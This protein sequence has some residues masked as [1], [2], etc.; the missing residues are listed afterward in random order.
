MFTSAASSDT[1]SIASQYKGYFENGRRYQSVSSNEYYQPAGIACPI[2]QAKVCLANYLPD[3]KQWE[4]MDEGHL[5][6]LIL[7]SQRSNPL[8]RSPVPKSAQ[9]I[10]DVGTGSGTWALEVADRW[11][12]GGFCTSV[13]KLYGQMY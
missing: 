1:T 2:D 4:A 9:N 12:S 5:L 13:H 7:D 11:P 8:F 6:F 3:E 10:I